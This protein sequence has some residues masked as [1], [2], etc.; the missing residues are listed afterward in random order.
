M[1]PFQ[2][3]RS[4]DASEDQQLTNENG[5]PQ[6]ELDEINSSSEVTSP[7]EPET[8]SEHPEKK[9]EA[10]VAKVIVRP[11]KRRIVKAKTDKTENPENAEAPETSESPVAESA[12]NIETVSESPSE[13][14][15][16][17]PVREKKK[18][19]IYSNLIMNLV[20]LL[21]KSGNPIRC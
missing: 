1:G 5:Q 20:F 15:Q 9:D 14:V 11:R 19:I 13:T 10:P 2:R 4:T 6:L 8:Q 7:S 16:E 12:E 21:S 17:V 18:F 3:H